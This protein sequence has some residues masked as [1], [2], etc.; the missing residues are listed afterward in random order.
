MP[1]ALQ[2]IS[3]V[4]ITQLEMVAYVFT[5]RITSAALLTSKAS[6]VSVVLLRCRHGVCECSSAHRS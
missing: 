5:Q 1:I 3:M 2:T 4:F 6:G